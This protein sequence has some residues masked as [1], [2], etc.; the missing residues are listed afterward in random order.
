MRC[1]TIADIKAGPSSGDVAAN[2]LC[3]K[4]STDTNNEVVNGI[5]KYTIAVSATS[6]V[7]VY[8]NTYGTDATA[9]KNA[10]KGVILAY[11]KA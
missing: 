2:I 1:S 5:R 6:V 7:I 4:Y 9:F 10:M 11:E 3:S 8:D